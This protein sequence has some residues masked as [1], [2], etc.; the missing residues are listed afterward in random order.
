MEKT[1]FVC[2]E[3]TLILVVPLYMTLTRRYPV[4]P[5]S[6]DMALFS[7]FLYAAYHSPVL[8]ISSLLSGYN[9]NYALVPPACKSWKIGKW[10]TH[11]LIVEP[12]FGIVT[13]L[14]AAGPWYRFIM[15]TS[16]LLLMFIT[17]YGIVENFL[18]L[19]QQ[20]QIMMLR[21]KKTA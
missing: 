16:A 19:V 14:I 9:L 4:L 6:L 15:Y 2:V 12:F 3:H 17:R 11:V 13:F 21:K 1:D 10:K 5:V 8:H 18:I 20:I 7:F